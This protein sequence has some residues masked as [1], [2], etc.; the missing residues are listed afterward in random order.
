M[1]PVTEWVVLLPISFDEKETHSKFIK[2]A[3]NAHASIVGDDPFHLL[4][5]QAGNKR[6][7][8]TKI[9]TNV[10]RWPKTVPWTLV[11]IQYK[12]ESILN[13]IAPVRFPQTNANIDA[14]TKA[15]KRLINQIFNDCTDALNG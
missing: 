1:K 15:I 9:A 8:Y 2:H 6:K 11:V 4:E 3:K 10:S 14:K 13:L 7:C 5:E 12:L